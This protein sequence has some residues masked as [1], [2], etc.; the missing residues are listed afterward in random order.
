MA[1][2]PRLLTRFDDVFYAYDKPA[3]MAVHPNAEGLD[4]LVSWLKAQRSL[5]RDLKPGHRLDRPTSGVVLCGVGRKARAQIS[6]WLQGG[7]EK[8]YLALVAG[9]PPEDAG[10]FDHPLY[11]ERREKMLKTETRFVVQ[12]RFDGFTLLELQLVTGRKHQLRRHLADAGM[13]VVGDERYGPRRP[14]R[15]PAFPGRLWLHAWRLSLPG[16]VIEA[17]LPPDLEE[18]IRALQ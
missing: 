18:N 2:T 13:P 14:R 3:G 4:D 9:E 10:S 8:H 16:R 17:A 15:V 12:Q 6:E 7:A 1:Q 5:P 11:D